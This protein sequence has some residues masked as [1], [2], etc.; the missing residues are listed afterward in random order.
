MFESLVLHKWILPVVC[1]QLDCSQFAYA[2]RPG[3]GTVSALLLT[4]H[5]VLCL[6]DSSSGAV[7][8][9]SA[10]FAKAFDS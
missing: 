8:F 10:D 7:R 3:S 5:R 2:P 1:D 6:S 4:V 9:L